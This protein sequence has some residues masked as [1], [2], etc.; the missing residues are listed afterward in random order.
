VQHGLCTKF[1]SR[2]AVLYGNG[3]YFADASCKASQYADATPETIILICRVIVGRSKLLLCPS[4]DDF[5]PEGYHSTR[6][7]AGVTK[8]HKCA[9]TTP[10]CLQLHNEVIVY[11]DCEVYPEF[12]LEHTS[13]AAYHAIPI[14]QKHGIRWNTD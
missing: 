13:P 14:L 6:V 7:E 2:D 10:T 8:K 9:R 12:V 1:V 5:A 11:N 3:L 4:D